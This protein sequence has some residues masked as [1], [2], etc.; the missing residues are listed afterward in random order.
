M[1]ARAMRRHLTAVAQRLE[2]TTEPTYDRSEGWSWEWRDGPSPARVAQELGET[3]AAR[4]RL[5]RRPS[6]RAAALAV[7]GEALGGTDLETH[8]AG[9]DTTIAPDA[10][11]DAL[12]QA[13]AAS[14]PSYGADDALL[15]RRHLHQQG[16]PATLLHP[17]TGTHGPDETDPLA[18]TA[19]E[20]LTARYALPVLGHDTYD[21]WRRHLH[22]APDAP[23]LARAALA[24][25]E[26]DR[27]TRL[28]AVAMLGDLRAEMEA[29]EDAAMTAAT[30]AG[31]SY[32]D[33]GR[34]MGVARQVAH[35]RHSRRA[36]G[37][38]ARLSP[39]RRQAPAPPEP[40][41]E[42]EDDPEDTAETTPETA[43]LADAR[44]VLAEPLASRVAQV[45]QA[46]PPAAT[47][48]HGRT[49]QV[50]HHLASA[51]RARNHHTVH[52]AVEAAAALR[53]RQRPLS[54]HPQLA[55][56]LHALH[57]EVSPQE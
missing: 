12:A 21:A 44:A 5:A 13:L 6:P 57:A 34:A 52:S 25:A 56:A 4:V 23:G 31:A 35:R 16:G 40:E 10:R 17:Y 42:P 22:L 26:A 29:L 18:M 39:Q 28:A 14:A 3:G 36:G 41:E 24:D 54:A 33:L 20:H 27:A 47:L 32:T 15:L 19:V 45:L 11:T 53:T 7:I 43:V 38:P 55:T 49:H 51:I 30:E 9:E 8:L 1:D 46:R 50:L 37:H 48:G 2:I